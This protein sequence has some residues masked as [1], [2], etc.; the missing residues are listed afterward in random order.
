MTVTRAAAQSSGGGGSYAPGNPSGSFSGE[1]AYTKDTDTGIIYIVNKAFSQFSSVLVDGTTLTRNTQYTAV[2]SS[3]KITLIPVYLDTLSI[4]TYTLR[5]NFTDST[6]ATATFTIAESEAQPEPEPEPLVNPFADI[7]EDDWF[8]DDVMY[9]YTNGLMTGTSAATFSPALTL[10]RGMV[11]TM[12]W[13]LEGEPAIS[14]DMP[15][16]MFT[17]V[18]ESAYYSNAV[19]WAAANGIVGGYGGGLFG[20]NDNITRQD[21]A[22]ILMRYMNFKGIVKPVTQQYIIFADEATISDYAMDAIQTFNK[23]GIINGTG[24]NAQGKTVIDPKGNATRAQV[25]A[26]LHRFM[27]AIK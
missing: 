23:L 21:L 8:Y 16:A 24:I 20:P 13:R 12:L 18:D 3:T 25:A 2:E 14:G 19:K 7:S 1:S 22:V 17:D 5:V 27:E 11:V 15:L 10:T 26:I 4:G 6:Y 9:V